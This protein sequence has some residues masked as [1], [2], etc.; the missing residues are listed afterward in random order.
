MQHSTSMG[1]SVE[2]WTKNGE[3]C[4]NVFT[5]YTLQASERHTIFAHPALT[6]PGHHS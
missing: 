5:V 1:L 2:A 6:G 4:G 3:S